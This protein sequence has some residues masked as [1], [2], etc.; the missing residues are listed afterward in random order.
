MSTATG[1]AAG[2]NHQ[3]KSHGRRRKRDNSA[4]EE[5]SAP[6]NSGRLSSA[7]AN[8]LA[9]NNAPVAA[10]AHQPPTGPSQSVPRQQ[11][12]RNPGQPHQAAPNVRSVIAQ[13]RSGSQQGGNL[14]TTSM[15]SGLMQPPPP[16][17]FPPT[18]RQQQQ[19]QQQQ[20]QQDADGFMVVQRTNNKSSR[21]APTTSSPTFAG[22]ETAALLA[23]QL[24]ERTEEI[25]VQW[26]LSR[27]A[28][29]SPRRATSLATF[30]IT[31]QQPLTVSMVTDRI[32]EIVVDGRH[33]EEMRSKLQQVDQVS[34]VDLMVAPD[35]DK[36]IQRLAFAYIRGGYFKTLRR[37]FYEKFRLKEDQIKVLLRAE[38]L[39]PTMDLTKQHSL[40]AKRAI[41][42]IGGGGGGGGRQQQEAEEDLSPSPPTTH[43][44]VLVDKLLALLKKGN[45][46]TIKSIPSSLVRRVATVYSDLMKLTVEDPNNIHL[47]FDLFAFPRT[48]LLRPPRRPPDKRK[49]TLSS[50]ERR[51][52]EESFYLARIKRWTESPSSRAALIQE[53]LNDSTLLPS[54]SSGTSPNNSSPILTKLGRIDSLMCNGQYADA[55]TALTSEG[56]APLTPQVI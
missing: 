29:E 3:G 11:G 37:F 26:N 10:V 39:L 12:N 24:T 48:V 20:Q 34:H 35:R 28:K 43:H 8:A 22:V 51:K 50:K 44:A 36:D 32:S 2:G 31:G 53:V 56:L 42:R 52:L 18:P 5:P 6:S 27:L 45:I 25:T 54:S 33:F 17:P 46:W 23:P 55:M 14:G 40:S 41:R 49:T 15:P 13:P 38:K 30:G 4:L 1:T 9:S 47:W 21:V 7:I 19:R 16:P